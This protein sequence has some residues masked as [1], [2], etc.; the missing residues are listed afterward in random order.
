M[1]VGN[2]DERIPAPMTW[3]RALYTVEVEGCLSGHALLVQTKIPVR[4]TRY[5]SFVQ[6][7]VDHQCAVS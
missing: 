1:E 6:R 2:D 3:H 5:L 4:V 7:F